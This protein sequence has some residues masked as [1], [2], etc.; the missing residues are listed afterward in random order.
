MLASGHAVHD[1]L[2]QITAARSLRHMGQ[3]AGA[4]TF[5]HARSFHDQSFK[6]CDPRSAILQQQLTRG[7]VTSRP[8]AGQASVVHLPSTL[9]PALHRRHR[10]ACLE[11]FSRSR[12]S[13]AHVRMRSNVSDACKATMSAMTCHGA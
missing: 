6:P 3:V 11:N 12:A 9:R 7:Q 8:L 10:G 2:S 4:A 1:R 13:A 5:C